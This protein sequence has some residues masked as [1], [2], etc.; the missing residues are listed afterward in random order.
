MKANLHVVLAAISL[1]IILSGCDTVQQ[2]L[3]GAK[4]PTASLQGVSF[5]DVSTSSATL[6][7]DV[8]VDNPYSVDLP[9]LNMDYAVAS[10]ANKLFTGKAD[11]QSAIPANGKK[12]ISLPA[13][14][15]Y[16]D[17]AKAFVGVKPGSSIPYN[18]DLG[19]SFNTPVL[20]NIRLP[21][22]KKGQLAVPN[23]PDLN[24]SGLEK[25]LL[26]TAGIKQ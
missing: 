6:L 4:K 11:V 26:D 5:G 1:T 23:I 17:L 12:T 2:A 24:K 21:L 20:G 22:N 3:L 25:M 16:L 19:L 14:I 7:F 8:Q 18:A 10:G 13:S 9:L 15:S